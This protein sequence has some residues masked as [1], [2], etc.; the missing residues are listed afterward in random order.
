MYN[1]SQ[2]L[3]KLCKKKRKGKHRVEDDG[4]LELGE[5]GKMGDRII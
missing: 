5:V 4:Y 2:A 3:I 1:N